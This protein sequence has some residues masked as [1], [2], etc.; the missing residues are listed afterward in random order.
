MSWNFTAEPTNSSEKD[1]GLPR[2]GSN[3][4][5]ADLTIAWSFFFSSMWDNF[6][7]RFKSILADL[8]YHS[9]LV[10]KEAIAIDIA[11]SSKHQKEDA[12][13]FEKQEKE[14]KHAK[15]N[16]ALSWLGFGSHFVDPK[17]DTLIRDCSPGSCE[18]LM[19]HPKIE[20]W[21][22]DQDPCSIVWLHG[23]PGA[24]E[25]KTAQGGF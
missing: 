22:Q 17:L 25:L 19:Q 4:V 23:K 10:E 6:D 24:G 16:A 1:V 20:P 12:E 5:T 15:L 8:A 14:W 11:A 18:W 9:D 21:L 13:R 2:H 7:S 3:T